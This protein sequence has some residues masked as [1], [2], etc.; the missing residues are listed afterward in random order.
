MA[1][2]VASLSFDIVA[3][4]EDVQADL[5][6]LDRG[7]GSTSAWERTSDQATPT[8]KKERGHRRSRRHEP[9]ASEDVGSKMS[10]QMGRRSRRPSTVAEESEG[11]AEDQGE[12]EQRRRAFSSVSPRRRPKSPRSGSTKIRLT[13]SPRGAAA[14]GERLQCVGTED[15]EEATPSSSSASPKRRC[16]KPRRATRRRLASAATESGDDLM[17]MFSEEFLLDGTV[18]VATKLQHPAQ[19]EDSLSG[20][21]TCALSSGAG[22]VGLSADSDMESYDSTASEE[23]AA[24]AA[25]FAGFAA[26]SAASFAAVAAREQTAFPLSAAERAALEELAWRAIV[27]STADRASDAKFERVSGCPAAVCPPL[28]RRRE[29]ALSLARGRS[30]ACEARRDLIEEDLATS[31]QVPEEAALA[32]PEKA[33]EVPLALMPAASE[34]ARAEHEVPPPVPVAPRPRVATQG[35]GR[36]CRQCQTSYT[37]FGNLC[38]GCRKAGPGGMVR[39]CP[40]CSSFF[41]GF[42]THCEDCIAPGHL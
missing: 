41:S 10:E 1:D 22:S 27:E 30:E 6:W 31:E 7:F 4:R 24:A 40:G 29:L 33:P 11:Q 5:E 35:A 25:G 19:A 3:L 34:A 14:G 15:S 37:G 38:G 2:I 8:S 26:S 23:L 13:A 42:R 20:A 18:D 17:R 16:K 12:V 32:A 28:W 9:A 39:Q 36:C 21:E